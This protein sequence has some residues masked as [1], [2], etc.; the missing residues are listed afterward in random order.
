MSRDQRNRWLGI[1]AIAAVLYSIANLFSPTVV[2]GESMAPTLKS[3]KLIWVDRTHYKLHRPQAGEVVVF[4]LDGVTYVKRIYRGPGETIHYLASGIDWIGPVRETR[5]TE[6][7]RRYHRRHSC[8]GVKSIRVPEDSV[9]VLG[10]NYMRSV[11]SRQIGPI[12]LSCI[13]GRAR[14]SVDST[15]ATQWEFVPSSV[16]SAEAR[17]SGRLGKVERRRI[18]K[19]EPI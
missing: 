15:R 6:M 13:L 7:Q 17:K 18:A 19:A 1:T 11:D 12:P 10:D 9:F 2:V 4:K 8:V 3:G 16:R 14:L 5:V